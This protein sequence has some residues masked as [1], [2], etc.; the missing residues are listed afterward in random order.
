MCVPVCLSDCMV[1]LECGWSVTC[2]CV[3]PP[4]FE[5]WARETGVC[6]FSSAEKLMVVCPMESVPQVK[7]FF[8]QRKRRR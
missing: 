7:S 5:K 6:L 8:E 2:E 3:P 1:V 4:Q